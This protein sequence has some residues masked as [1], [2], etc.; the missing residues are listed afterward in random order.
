MD[1]DYKDDIVLRANAPAL[2][3]SLLQ[4][5]EQAAGGVGFQVNVKK[6]KFEDHYISFQTFSHGKFYW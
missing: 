5:L 3:E 2:A 4:S 1:A 6:M